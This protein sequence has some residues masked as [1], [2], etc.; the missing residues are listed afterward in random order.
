MELI[1]LS[2]VSSHHFKH[3][4]VFSLFS[5]F[6]ITLHL[7]LQFLHPVSGVSI[8]LEFLSPVIISIK[9]LTLKQP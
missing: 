1:E 5:F 4:F 7:V 2:L 8:S 3:L 9:K 6:M